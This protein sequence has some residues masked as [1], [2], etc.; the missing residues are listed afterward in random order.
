MKSI[1]GAD[2][3]VFRGCAEAEMARCGYVLTGLKFG[4]KPDTLIG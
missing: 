4:D 1:I 2:D 3:S